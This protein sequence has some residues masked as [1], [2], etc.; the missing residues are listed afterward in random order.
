MTLQMMNCLRRI[1]VAE[2]VSVLYIR[3]ACD[4]KLC[5]RKVMPSMVYSDENNMKYRLCGNPN[6]VGYWVIASTKN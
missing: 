4:L 3:I 6:H 5:N 2:T 1:T